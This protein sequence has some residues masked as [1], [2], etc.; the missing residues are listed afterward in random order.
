[1][2]KGSRRLEHS[3]P[4]LKLSACRSELKTRLGTTLSRAVEE[5]NISQDLVEQSDEARLGAVVTREAELVRRI[6]CPVV[7]SRQ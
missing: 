3:E 7:T 4:G 5:A 2:K 1:M 6:D